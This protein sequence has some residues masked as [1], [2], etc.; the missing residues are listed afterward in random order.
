MRLD[1]RSCSPIRHTIVIDG[2]CDRRFAVVRDVFAEGFAHRDEVGAAVAVTLDGRPV[3]DL[4]G[5]HADAARTRRWE[6]DTIVHVFSTT[7]AMTALCAH[8]LAERGRLDLAAP[9]A[10]YWPEFAQGGKAT[11]P[12]HLTLSHR[13]G[14]PAI[15]RPLPPEAMFEW[16]T[17]TGALAAEEP[18]WE[19]G[20]KHGYHLVTYGWLVGEVVRRASGK[21][22]GTFFRDE[23]AGPLGLDCHIGLAAEHDGRTAETIPGPLPPPGDPLFEALRDRDSMQFKAIANPPWTPE[24][25]NTRAWRAAEIPAVNAH[26]NA[27]ALARLYGVLACGGEGDGVRLLRPETLARA[28]EQQCE[29][30]DAVTGLPGRLA[31]G[32][33]LSLPEWPLGPGRRS[34]GHPG[35]GGSVGFADPEA[36]LGFGYTPNRMGAGLDLRDPRTIALIDAVYASL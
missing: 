6:R 32:F 23:V 26:T 8:L 22:V 25:V 17:V 30:P 5:G 15:R 16:E 21:S 33:G 18:W 24:S 29:G 1:L 11:L 9:V 4:W 19:P 36:R 3:V 13:A 2:T 10:R 7:K 35:A 28:T 34:F 12:V 31:L 14:L 20:T 27:R